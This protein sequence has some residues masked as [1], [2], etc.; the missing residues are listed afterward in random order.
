MSK[1]EQGNIDKYQIRAI[2]NENT[3]RVYQAYNSE[4]AK[5]A[6]QNQTFVS[7]PWKSERTT[8]IKPSFLWMMYRSGWSRK[9]KNQE[10]ILAIDITIDG[11]EWILDNH[12]LSSH[13]KTSDIEEEEQQQQQQQHSLI[14]VQWD[15]ER[16]INL[17]ARGDGMR[18]IQIGIKK[19][20]VPKFV[21]EW[22][23]SIT[24]ITDY[25][26]SIKHELDS[27]NVELAKSMLPKEE[28]YIPRNYKHPLSP[29]N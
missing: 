29:K 11:F 21:N 8:W 19:G 13:I 25:C 5:S 1:Q 16:T 10:R 12:I 17:G 9:D 26:L 20:A 14:V 27:G 7:P 22:I 23:V 24:D 2:Y 3:I 18:S 6:V 4:I 15:P 28:L